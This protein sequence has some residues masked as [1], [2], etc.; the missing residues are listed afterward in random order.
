MA[1]KAK[2]NGALCGKI[3]LPG[4]KSIS[5]RAIIIAALATGKTVIRN[6][7]MSTD[8]L[9]TLEAVR[10]MQV[11]VVVN[12][13]EYFV[14]VD[15]VGL[16][17]L[18]APLQT[19]DCG[20]SGTAMRLLTGLLCA[21]AF[22]AVLVGD[23]SLSRRP[24]RRVIEPLS[25]MGATLSTRADGTP[26]ITIQ[27][28][29]LLHGIT[30]N[31]PVPSAQVRSAILLAALYAKGETTVVEPATARDHTYRM[32]KYFG[33]D[34][35]R[36]QQHSITLSGGGELTAREI[37]VPGDIS[38]AAFFIVAA[39][40]T[41]H[42]SITLLSVGVNPGRVGIINIL[43]LM[44]ADIEVT[45]YHEAYGEPVA[46]IWVRYAPLHAI[47]I[48]KSQVPL[49]IDE[50][51]AILIAAA[52]AT[53]ITRLSGAAE[54]RVKE[55]DRIEAMVH[56]LKTLGIKAQ[57][58]PDGAIIEGGVMQAGKIDSHGDHRIAM[59]FAIAANVA[60]GAI[61]IP[62]TANIQTSFPNFLELAQQIGMDIK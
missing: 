44:G 4:D 40:I 18:R 34:R 41:P 16:V 54:L 14:T 13:K 38:S 31:M 36:K 57:A 49:A 2:K 19:I 3:R 27:E 20:N 61:N 1:L 25:Q 15:G 46:D 8:C 24:M 12:Q 58:T 47:D 5:H 43:K 33:Y 35:L 51:P 29:T 59:A 60:L 28:S 17:G 52:A 50:L 48:P 62:D 32:L 22:N 30:Y 7:L 9:A 53:G 11:K 26:P 6:F 42:S 55:T 10:Q 37:C 45:N 56:G 23:A 39:A 21:Q